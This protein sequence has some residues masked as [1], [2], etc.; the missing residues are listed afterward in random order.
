MR[1]PAD[2]D[3]WRRI[4]DILD[5][6]LE[7]PPAERSAVLD[8][9]CG[10]SAELRS[11]VEALLAADEQAGGLLEES[12][13]DYAAALLA[14]P[15]ESAGSDSVP[16]GRQ[17]GPYRV[18][19]EIGSGGMGV[20]YEGWDTRLDRRVALKLLPPEWGRSAGAKERFVREARAAAAL[21][22][23][24]ICTVHDVGESDD[25][26]LFIVMAYYQGD[27]LERRIARGPIPPAEARDLAI[28]IARGLER[29]HA[30][31]VIHRDVKPSNVMVTET[32]SD[33]VPTEPVTAD[34]AKILDFGIAR[35]AGEAGLTR[36]G[37]SP[38]TPAYMS[39]EQASGDPI[40]ERTDIWSLGV[41]LYE[42]LAGRR[43]FHGDHPQ[44]LVHAILERDPE[45][46]ALEVPADL[47]RVVERALAREPA[48]RYQRIG[49]LLADL[50]RRPVGGRWRWWRQAAA[51]ATGLVLFG[52]W[53]SSHQSPVPSEPPR[54]K[55]T[56]SR[57]APTAEAAVPVI[58]VVPFGNRTGEAELD[59]YGEGVARLVAD[60]LAPSRHLLV[61]SAQRIEPLLGAQTSAELA[62]AAAEDGI[63]F[64]VTGEILR[65]GQGLSLAARLSA[66]GDGRQLA[67]RRVTGLEPPELLAAADEIARE[68]RKGLGVPPTEAVDVLAADFASDNPAAYEL[69]LRGLRAIAGYRY[70]E[71]EQAFVEALEEAP[72]FT[73]ARYRLAHVE[74]VTSRTAE[75]LETIGR[76]V[77]EANRLPDREARYVRA[78]E[79]YISRRY[80]E[81][82]VAYRR[83]LE[84]YPYETEAAHSLARIL[85]AR[86]RYEEVLEITDL[87]A[88]LEPDNHITWSQSGSA[89]LA[90]G[91]YH[92]ATLDLERYAKLEPRSANAR[93]LL[94]DVYRAQGELELAATE[95]FVALEVDPSFHVSAI[96]LAIT[97]VLR[98]RPKE[99]EDRLASLVSNLDV[100]PRN[101]ISAAFELVSLY[102]AQGRFREA[103]AVLA[104][105]EQVIAEEQVRE[106]M[107]LAV[108]GASRMELGEIRAARRL[109]DLAVER[110]PGVPTRYL[111][112][113]GL[114]ELREGRSAALEE[115]VSS[116]LQGA[117][118]EGD[119]DRTEEK[120]AAYLR[121][122]ARLAAGEIDE[123][124]AEL[125]RA[126]ALEGYEYAVYR[127][128]LARAYLAAKRLREALAAARLAVQDVDPAEPRLDLGLDRVRALLV[129][130]RVQAALGQPAEAAASAR[131]LL[132]R[133]AQG[134]QGLPELDEARRLAAAHDG[135]AAPDERGTTVAG[136]QATRDLTASPSEWKL[137]HLR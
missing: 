125:T 14:E 85:H 57:R 112:T 80:D 114:L 49:H 130:A 50:E 56:A 100:N 136:P 68:T 69:Y 79:H 17:L 77:A 81:A 110:S 103:T 86:K 29:A 67:G 35:V 12:V 72:G 134:H 94:G 107:A 132:S 87:L 28:Q 131:E 66:T 20:V 53:W 65:T 46:L 98:E 6:V 83:I 15:S 41:I 75:A 105:L 32:R 91:D 71:A 10:D 73:M 19:R 61:V 43:P 59:W 38:G 54:S 96:A 33:I 40:D 102:R 23:P 58:G 36:A 108:R 51:L 9:A 104:G 4:A 84:L 117:R 78:L 92:R 137:H 126:V 3:S 37:G 62:E 133:W 74:A 124:T 1:L 120:A 27:T 90:L 88:R 16:L 122:L 70:D 7:M 30:A 5:R 129:L 106:A 119:P 118:P 76:A 113:R 97:D 128:G 42:M 39:P 44:A 21:D 89:H 135:Q 99:A 82:A 63:E 127:L 64:L 47:A 93:H 26:Q 24:N 45:P 121:G 109:L 101:R 22:H 55:A 115:T 123:A 60:A 2:R 52:L 116:I 11:E 34:R 13:D 31:G 8:E 95:Y 25:G 48:A 111:F 18:V